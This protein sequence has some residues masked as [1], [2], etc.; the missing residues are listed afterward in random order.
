VRMARAHLSDAFAHALTGAEGFMV[1][2]LFK[3]LPHTG[4]PVQLSGVQGTL[5]ATDSRGPGAARQW[6]GLRPQPACCCCT[7][8][9]EAR[10]RERR[11]GERDRI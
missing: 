3:P 8:R 7:R 5:R 10:N 11:A 6:S 9:H 2:K 1:L 4:Q